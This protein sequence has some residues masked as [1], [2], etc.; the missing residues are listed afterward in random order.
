MSTL[1]A[2]ALAVGLF[3]VSPPSAAE[4]AE[5]TAP[6]P[7]EVEISIMK[8]TNI[9]WWPGANLPDWVRALD[10]QRVRVVGYMAL[11]TPEGAS[12][13]RQTWDQCGCASAKASHFIEVAL[14]EETTGYNPDQITVIGTMSVGE[15]EEDGFVTSLFR[16]AAESVL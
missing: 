10:G 6:A 11:D 13:F 12:S 1:H 7:D 3:S 14:G 15:K 5:F 2:F 16:I 4:P 8:L 9:E